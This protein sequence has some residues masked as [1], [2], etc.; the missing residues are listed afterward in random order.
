MTA[1]RE[2][3][4]DAPTRL[5]LNWEDPEFSDPEALDRELER[6]F[7]IC[8]GC[9]RCVNLCQAFPTLFDL[10]DESETLEVDGIDRNDYPKVVEQ[11]Y[12]CDLCF[13]TKCPYVPPHEWNVDFPHLM[14]RAKYARFKRQSAPLRD[15][16]LTATDRTG[17]FLGIPIVAPAVNAA[18][19]NRPARQLLHRTVG[20]HRDAELPRFH[21]R[22]ARRAHRALQLAPAAEPSAAPTQA[23]A[24]TPAKALVF[25]TCYGNRNRPQLIDDL[26][27]VLQHNRVEVR[28]SQTE[29]CCGMPKFELGDLD[30]VRKLKDAN[31]PPLRD[32][33]AQGYTLLAPVP[34]CVL[35]FRK[36]LP[37]LFPDD[38]DVRR[39]AA[40]FQDPFEYLH[41]LHKDGRLDLD[42]KQPLGRVAMHAACHQRV[43]NIG[44][45]TRDV[46]ELV[47]DTKL[48]AIERCSGHDGTYAV[49]TETHAFARKICRPIV[50]QLAELEPDHYGSDCPLAGAHIEHCGS[51]DR[52]A[53]HPL[54]LLRYAYG[55]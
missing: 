52:P 10:V 21:A 41:A 46:L 17:Q 27:D 23:A 6:V 18:N 25:A 4:L 50:R 38:P 39:V 1:S 30:S 31:L 51:F 20:I 13:M 29:Q 2:G 54:S 12:L 7:D 24:R 40:G 9:R 14:L 32:A 3:S 8:H 55:L 5:P 45:K 28:F 26:V 36:E 37:L 42:F 49:K 33:V 53:E 15:R 47:P 34:S 35:M 16:L 19:R 48:T 44:N 43:Q 22:S 11:C